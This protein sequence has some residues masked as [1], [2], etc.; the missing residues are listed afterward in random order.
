M[1]TYF[2]P[3]PDFC[4]VHSYF[5]KGFVQRQCG[6]RINNPDENDRSAW[7]CYLGVMELG[8]KK[9]LGAIL[10]ASEVPQ[11]FAE[12]IESNDVY[13]LT[14]SSVKLLCRNKLAADY[15]WFQ[16][17]SG[18]RISVSEDRAHEVDDEFR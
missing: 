16:H 13:G 6:I 7:K 14:N 8:K 2:R 15:C 17:P 4:T 10:D 12:E 9:T 18:R 3:E 11:K 5:G 1:L